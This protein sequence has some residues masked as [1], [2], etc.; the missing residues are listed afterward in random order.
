MP[1]TLITLT[2]FTFGLDA[3]LL[4]NMLKENDIECFLADENIVSVN[5]F[6]TNAVGGVRLQIWEKDL[7]KATL[8][9]LQLKREKSET[10]KKT[11]T[12]WINDFEKFDTYCPQCESH[13]VYTP[14]VSFSD[15]I[16]SIFKSKNLYC[17]D[18]NH[19]W[20]E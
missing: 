3:H 7:E 10:E 15:K 4:I 19:V 2:T 12:K 8:I 11:D 6:L 14:K 16:I 18:C 5:P 20:T 17:S 13:E 9:H 1:D